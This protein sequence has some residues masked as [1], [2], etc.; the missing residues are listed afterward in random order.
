M[1]GDRHGR[2]RIHAQRAGR[3]CALDHDPAAIRQGRLFRG[4]VR[5]ARVLSALRRHCRLT[6]RRPRSQSAACRPPGGHVRL[7]QGGRRCGI[8]RPGLGNLSGSRR[9]QGSGRRGCLC[10]LRRRDGRIRAGGGAAVL[11]CRRNRGLGPAFFRS[12]ACFR[13]RAG[14]IRIGRRHRFGRNI[15]LC[16]TRAFL[17][18]ARKRGVT[19]PHLAR[20]L[21]RRVSPGHG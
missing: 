4:N 13:T 3:G 8:G 21:V 17:C 1:L 12:C 16:L 6:R 9:L 10:P 18:L 7:P 5:P 20:H 14:R 19:A 2:W 15:R 11:V